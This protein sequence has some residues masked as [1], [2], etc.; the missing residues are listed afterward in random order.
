MMLT[1]A[2]LTCTNHIEVVVE[3]VVMVVEAAAAASK[4]GGP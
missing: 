4:G 3:W 1:C 2:H